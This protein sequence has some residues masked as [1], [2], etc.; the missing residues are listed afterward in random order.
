LVW[1]EIVPGQAAG[2]NP[3]TQTQDPVWTKIAA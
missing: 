2:W 1:N 3:I